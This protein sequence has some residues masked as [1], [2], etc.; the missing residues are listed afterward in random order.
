[1]FVV[2]KCRTFFFGLVLSIFPVLTQAQVGIG[3]TIP[4]SSAALDVKSI[5]QGLLPP[6][7]DS[8]QRDAIQTPAEG[9]VI[10]NTTEKCLQYWDGVEWKCAVGGNKGSGGGAAYATDLRFQSYSPIVAG[11]FVGVTFDG[12]LYAWGTQ[13]LTS[14]SWCK[15]SDKPST[16]LGAIFCMAGMKKEQD[17]ADKS[18]S[19]YENTSSVKSPIRIFPEFNNVKKVSV[20]KDI[21]S[22]T[23][24]FL[25]TDNKLY[26]VGHGIS[27]VIPALVD[28]PNN[29][30]AVD[31][32]SFSSSFHTTVVVTDKG[33]IYQRGYLNGLQD[34][35]P[36][37]WHKV[38]KP[39]GVSNDFKFQRIWIL[40][41]YSG[42][43]MYTE[44]S[45][46]NYYAFGR[47]NG[48]AP[49]NA[50]LGI[51]YGAGG[52][53]F[54]SATPVK[55][56]LPDGTKIK[57]L[58]AG[59]YATIAITDTG[60]AY[61]WGS[62]EDP[63]Y[64][65]YVKLKVAPTSQETYE[66][67]VQNKIVLKEP[68]ELVLPPG[69]TKFQTVM[70]SYSARTAHY[71]TD[72]GVYMMGNKAAQGNG[73]IYGHFDADFKTKRFN[74][75]EYVHLPALPNNIIRMRHDRLKLSSALG[76]DGVIWVWGLQARF[77]QIH[78]N[79]FESAV[80]VHPLHGKHDPFNVAP[81]PY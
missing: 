66:I 70:F 75:G 41:D 4:D 47:A 59:V 54:Q 62:T 36:D 79:G 13:S 52:T 20:A 63:G 3:T 19:L 61:M 81:E 15:L 17:L 45:D 51:S 30:K 39:N 58:I 72:N 27:S 57:Q 69:A 11:M 34:S 48:F 35:D 56:N 55:V 68:K 64:G 29:E 6:R 31:F 18:I 44:G 25:T 5:N 2:D 22:I 76:E 74:E 38:P 1:M 8:A 32:E 67:N 33:N 26:S 21:G 7:M 65:K 78:P 46:G 77:D 53:A 23:L 9:L 24:T 28:L 16:A 50:S 12:E 43:H 73:M 40:E 42:S 60:K 10:Y 80:P 49:G 37:N 71:A 14:L